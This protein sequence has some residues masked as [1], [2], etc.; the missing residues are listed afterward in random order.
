MKPAAKYMV[1]LPG[2]GMGREIRALATTV[3]ELQGKRHSAD[4]D[5]TMRFKAV[6]A[7]DAITSAR[8]ALRSFGE[9]SPDDRKLF[10]T[11]LLCPPR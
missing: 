10:L 8:A 7:A 1:Y 4:Y 3:R 6:D 2:T 11:L 5:P 9:A